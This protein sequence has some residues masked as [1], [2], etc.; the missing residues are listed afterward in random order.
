MKAKLIKVLCE[1][2]GD[3]TAGTTVLRGTGKGVRKNAKKFLMDLHRVDPQKFSGCKTEAQFKALL[4]K[5]TIELKGTLPDKAKK[6]WGVARKM[7]NLYLRDMLYYRYLCSHFGFCHLEN[8]LKYR[9]IAGQLKASATIMNM[10]GLE[11]C[12]YPGGN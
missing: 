5:K 8:G 1:R 9:L 3:V 10:M 2:T 11:Y 7:L 6:N 12:T 4:D